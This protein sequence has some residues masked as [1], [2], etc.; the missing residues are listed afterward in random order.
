MAAAQTGYCGENKLKTVTGATAQQ[1]V[2]TA[3]GTDAVAET[4]VSEGFKLAQ[5]EAEKWSM[6]VLYPLMTRYRAR[7]YRRT[8]PESVVGPSLT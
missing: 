4:A 6:D 3:V 7:R 8:E 2:H 1:K 5:G